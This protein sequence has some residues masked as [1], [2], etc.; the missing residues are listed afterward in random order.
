MNILVVAPHPDDEAIGCGGTLCVHAS[1]GD[2][3][4]AVFLTSGELGIF[5]VAMN[6]V[7][8]IREREARAAAKILG[9]A[10]LAFLHCGDGSLNQEIENVAAGLR[11]EIEKEPPHIIYL[12][13][14]LEW[15]PDHKASI[16]IVRAALEEGAKTELRAYEIWTPLPDYHHVQD[17]S[18]VMERKLE[19][20][21]AHDSQ[22]KQWPYDRAIIGLNQYRGAMAGRCPYAEVFRVL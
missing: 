20:L 19:A 7:W 14:E 6:E 17:I 4:R 15:H 1:K 5:G 2:R 11:A 13:H 18:A 10:H 9:I 22:M 3:I 21:R 16:A 12:P 8:R